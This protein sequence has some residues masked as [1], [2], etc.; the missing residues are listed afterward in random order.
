[1]GERSCTMVLKMTIRTIAA[2]SI[3]LDKVSIGVVSFS[4]S[5]TATIRAV[6]AK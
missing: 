5:L 1:M 4:F 2:P 3:Q 6:N